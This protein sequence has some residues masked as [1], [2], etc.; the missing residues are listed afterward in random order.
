MRA[1]YFLVFFL[2]VQFF[3]EAQ[4]FTNSVVYFLD[5][6]CKLSQSKA[7]DIKETIDKFHG[8]LSFFFIL[9][10]NANKHKAKQYFNMFGN[11]R[12]YISQKSDR[13]CKIANELNA[14]IVPSVF[15]LDSSGTT[16]YAGALDNKDM[17]VVISK[18]S[19]YDKLVDQ[20]IDQYLKGEVISV[21]YKKPVGCVFR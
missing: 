8:K 5:P 18:N 1:L 20:A 16:I 9:P 19:S 11:S 6:E 21:S 10:K 14:N 3:I 15:V 17:S 4:N 7:Y 2:G 12:K 13:Q